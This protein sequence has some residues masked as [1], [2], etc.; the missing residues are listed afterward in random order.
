MLIAFAVVQVGI[1]VALLI[2]MARLLRERSAQ[3]RQARDREERLEALAVEVCAVAREL[4]RQEPPPVRIPPSA[5]RA[6]A[7]QADE[8]RRANS[9]PPPAPPYPSPNLGERVRGATALLEQG[10]AVDQVAAE[11]ALFPGEVQ[12]LRNLHRT[13]DAA[14]DGSEAEPARAP[15]RTQRTV[16]RAKAST[17]RAGST[18]AIRANAAETPNGRATASAAGAGDVHP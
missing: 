5:E 8:E 16:R 13:L 17:W 7:R 9:A 6:E 15:R 11:T 4:T 3:G 2:R 10:L 18:L 12:I 14:C 1:N